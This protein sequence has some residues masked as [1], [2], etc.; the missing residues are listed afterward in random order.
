MDKLEKLIKALR[1]NDKQIAVFLQMSDEKAC[2]MFALG[3]AVF[4]S[5]ALSIGVLGICGS[6]A[7]A[8]F[9]STASLAMLGPLSIICCNRYLR[10]SVKD[11][12]GILPRKQALVLDYQEELRMIDELKLPRKET[13]TLRKKAFDEYKVKREQLEIRRIG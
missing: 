4:L 3:V 12:T 8:T 13:V 2:R 10:G 7:V 6:V 5:A 9:V 1:G 11:P